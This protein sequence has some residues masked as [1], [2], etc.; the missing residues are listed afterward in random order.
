MRL[1]LVAGVCVAASV[2]PMMAAAQGNPGDAATHWPAIVECGAERSAAARHA[3]V[4]RVL[5]SAG[6]LSEA[7]VVQETREEFGRQNR[8]EAPR[9]PPTPAVAA[10]PASAAATAA[11]APAA[12]VASAAAPP[13]PARAAEIDKL[14]TSIAAVRT[15]GYR[16][17][18]VTTTD[19]SVWDQTRDETFNTPP[20]V[21]DTFSIERASL[22]SFQCRFA[23]ASN[24]RCERVD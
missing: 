10:A 1:R 14:V 19:G 15:I 6:V 20:K 21:G 2:M 24:Y 13:A 5:R 11:P 8:A 3:C 4:D 17:L 12:S 9:T 22:G 18:R 16:R 23:R 7:R